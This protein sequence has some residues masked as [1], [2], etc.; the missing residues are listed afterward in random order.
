M[1]FFQGQ[2]CATSVQPAFVHTLQTSRM[3]SSS[4]T[5]TPDL[6]S[7]WR[8]RATAICRTP[9]SAKWPEFDGI[10]CCSG[11]ISPR[12]STPSRSLPTGPQA[13]YSQVRSPQLSF[14]NT[15]PL[16]RATCHRRIR[17]LPFG[18]LLEDENAASHLNTLLPVSFPF[19]LRG[20]HHSRGG[21]AGHDTLHYAG[22][23]RWPYGARRE[24]HGDLPCPSWHRSATQ[25]MFQPAKP[26]H[27]LHSLPWY[28]HPEILT[29]KPR[30][31]SQHPKAPKSA[32]RSIR[33]MPTN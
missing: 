32:N 7:F 16:M 5:A 18:S 13:P 6:M 14:S 11:A 2:I 19:A 30:P 4:L 23:D 8:D 25:N 15:C 21:R 26:S 12:G 17:M 20:R 31:N 22:S 27:P 3:P 33:R 9:I 28:Q 10:S 24:H 29:P 1:T